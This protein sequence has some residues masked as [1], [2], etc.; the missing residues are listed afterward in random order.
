MVYDASVVYSREIFGSKYRFLFLQSAWALAGLFLLYFVS[1]VDYHHWLKFV[2]F[3]LTVSSVL[4]LL[5]AWPHLPLFKL[6]YPKFIFEKV[7]FLPFVY[8]AYRWVVVN[9]SPL[10]ELP[11]IGRFSFQPT[12]LAKLFFVLYFAKILVLPEKYLYKRFENSF[13]RILFT[14]FLPVFCLFTFL[15]VLQPDLGTAI[16]LS[17]IAGAEYFVSRA[18]LRYFFISIVLFSAIAFL[19]ILTSPYR[20]ERLATFINPSAAETLGS[21]YHIRQI[22]IALGSGG[23]TGLGFGQSRQKYEY[24]P[25][26]TTD[27]IFAVIG[28]EFGFIGTSLVIFL[29]LILVYNG[30][31]IARFAADETGRLIAFGITVW[32]GGQSLINLSAMAGLLPL[33]GVPLPLVSYGGSATVII[34]VALGILLNIDRQTMKRGSGAIY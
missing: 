17:V 30:F 4:L 5:L 14:R 19:F 12:E 11:F 7:N 26:V 1:K 32:L 23:L 28:E 22:M 6:I 16:I 24:L 3:L 27:S 15:T 21:G 34:L 13:R 25:E 18:P 9:P 33:T 2:P 20:R 29:F 31:R 8:G 10:P